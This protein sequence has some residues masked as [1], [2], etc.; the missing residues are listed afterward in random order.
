MSCNNGIA[1]PTLQQ[2]PCNGCRYSTLC[3]YRELP[4]TLLDIGANQPLET[5]ITALI[6]ALQSLN[7]RVAELEAQINP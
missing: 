6:S 4:S 5:Y 1:I 2:D 7:N 3:V